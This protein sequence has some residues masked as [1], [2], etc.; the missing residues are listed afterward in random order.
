[1]HMMAC[2]H[3]CYEQYLDENKKVIPEEYNKIVDRVK[4]KNK[5][6]LNER[7]YNYFIRNNYFTHFEDLKDF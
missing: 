2:C 4:E 3:L 5:D 7:Q 6:Q 1:M